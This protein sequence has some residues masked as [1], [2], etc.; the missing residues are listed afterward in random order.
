M[1]KGDYAKSE[2]VRKLQEAFGDDYIGESQKKYYVRVSDGGAQKIQIAISLT[3]PKVEL[4]VGGAASQVAT[5]GG[6]WDFD[7][8]ASSSPSAQV[9]PEPA[10]ITEQEQNNIAEMLRRLGL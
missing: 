4:E 7:T 8:A 1:A 5:S 10:E 3:C 2:V 9:K 6:G